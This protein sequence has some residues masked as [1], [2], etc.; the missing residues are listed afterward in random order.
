MEACQITVHVQKD[1]E[2]GNHFEES[3]LYDPHLCPPWGEHKAETAK[4]EEE[5]KDTAT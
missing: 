4:G 3:L 5:R 1:M 2:V